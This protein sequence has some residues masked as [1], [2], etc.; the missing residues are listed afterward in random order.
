MLDDSDSNSVL[1]GP[2]QTAT[3]THMPKRFKLWHS[4]VGLAA[5]LVAQALLTYLLPAGTS[6]WLTLLCAAAGAFA[7][8][9]V[10][11][12]VIEEVRNA[13]HML[14][15]LSI[16]V[17]ESVVFFAFEYAFLLSIAPQSFPTLNGDA[18]NFLLQS[19]MVFVFNPLYL[20][21]DLLGRMLLIINTASALVLVLFILQN[22]WQFRRSK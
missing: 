16:V 6:A 21:A 17:T 1:K 15:L 22:I 12:E 3:L 10:S 14:V 13:R 7:T 9:F 18:S 5:L 20:P 8:L 19:L 11:T 2:Q 4:F